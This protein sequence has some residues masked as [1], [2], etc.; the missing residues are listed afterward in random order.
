ME[1]GEKRFFL[2][3][4]NIKQ[5]MKWLVQ[6]WENKMNIS[7]SINLYDNEGDEIEKGLYIHNNE[8]ILKFKN[9]QNLINYKNQLDDI[10]KEIMDNNLIDNKMEN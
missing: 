7:F 8:V 2:M 1:L 9:L 6:Q 10:I 4:R 3:L 5:N